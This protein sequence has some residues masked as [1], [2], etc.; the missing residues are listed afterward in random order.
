MKGLYI[1]IFSR[2]FSKLI[3]RISILITIVLFFLVK[4]TLCAQ[5]VDHKKNYEIAKLELKNKNYAKAMDLF[6]KAS[7]DL[8]ENLDRINATYFYGYCAFK[9]KQYWS[10]NHYLIKLIEKYPTWNKISEV[11][12]GYGERA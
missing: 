9:Q 4:G 12:R 11:Y 10:A 3:N 8:P 7:N 6:K 2:V 1:K 5:K